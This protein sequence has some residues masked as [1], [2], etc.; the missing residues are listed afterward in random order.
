MQNQTNN[1]VSWKRIFSFL[2][3]A[4]TVISGLVAVDPS[5]PFFPTF[6]ITLGILLGII[7]ALGVPVLGLMGITL[8]V[9]KVANAVSKNMSFSQSLEEDD[10]KGQLAVLPEDLRE[11]G[12]I[13]LQ[14]KKG[15]GQV[16]LARNKQTG[17]VQR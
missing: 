12:R 7:V 4:V 16:A 17:E 11:E 5:Y 14:E 2:F 10:G 3:T 6:F 8:G 15:Q 13:S 9:T 1:G